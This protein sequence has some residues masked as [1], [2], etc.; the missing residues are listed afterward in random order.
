MDTDYDH[1]CKIVVVGASKVGKSALVRRLTRNE[2]VEGV[3][4]TIGVDFGIV[5]HQRIKCHIWD[6]AGQ[7]RFAPMTKQYMRG[8][9]S[10]FYVFDVNDDTSID[11][12]RRDYLEHH[13][14]NGVAEGA[15][16]ALV[17][18]QIDRDTTLCNTVPE[19]LSHFPMS[20]YWVSAKTGEHCTRL[21]D[22]VCAHFRRQQLAAAAR[23]REE[24]EEDILHISAVNEQPN[25]KD[26]S[27]C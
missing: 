1:V 2:Y 19:G 11:K 5:I 7:E 3:P 21:L 10:I 27:C 22:D 14:R 13:N 6:T 17:A 24:Q 4:S 20:M 12:L 8:A 18:T 25:A 23:T 15:F 16:E 26:G 9:Q